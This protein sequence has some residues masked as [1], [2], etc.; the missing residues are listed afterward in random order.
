[1]RTPRL[2]GLRSQWARIVEEPD[3]IVAESPALKEARVEPREKPKEKSQKGNFTLCSP[4]PSPGSRVRSVLRGL[5]EPVL[6][7]SLTSAE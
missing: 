2:A 6:A 7:E 5:A 4:L 1:M 3:L